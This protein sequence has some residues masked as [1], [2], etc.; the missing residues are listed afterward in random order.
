MFYEYK[1]KNFYNLNVGDRCTKTRNGYLA[2]FICF[3][4]CVKNDGISCKMFNDGSGFLENFY[5]SVIS[6]RSYKIIIKTCFALMFSF[7]GLYFL[8]GMAEF[9]Q[10]D[11]IKKAIKISFVYLMIGTDGWEFYNRFFVR[12]FKEGI[13]YLVFSIAAAFSDDEDINNAIIQNKLYDKTILF[14]SISNSLKLIISDKITA[15]IWGIFFSSLAGPIYLI[16][17]FYAI[18][19][20]LVSIL[21]ALLLYITSQFFISFLLAFGPIF[22]ALL[23]FEKTKNMFDKWISN[24][25]SFS[26]EQI[27]LITCISLFNSL[28]YNII[29]STFSYKV[30][31]EPLFSISIGIKKFNFFTFWRISENDI[32]GLFQ[33]LLIFLL[34]YLMKQFVQFM[35]DLGAKLGG[36]DLNSS[37]MTKEISDTIGSTTEVA[38]DWAKKNIKTLGVSVGRQLGYETK[39][40]RDRIDQTNKTLSAGRDK[41]FD[42]AEQKTAEQMSALTSGKLNEGESWQ[43]ALKNG[44]TEVKDIYERTLK[45][46]FDIAAGEDSKLSAA[47]KERGMDSSKLFDSSYFDLQQTSSFGGLLSNFVTSSIFNRG[48]TLDKAM[49][50]AMSESDSDENNNENNNEDENDNGENNNEN[51]GVLNPDLL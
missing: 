42:T 9:T 41:A 23:V 7:Y 43:D 8:L 33:V 32:P 6:D 17:I 24:L 12:F 50:R 38:K 34:A 46:N 45:R 4:K 19:L 48:R 20:F 2:E 29:K 14:N 15:R 39:E 5:K 47:L 13:D 35:A 31:V 16:L 51:D 22:F 21:T 3:K 27:F 25:I 26:L 44:N 49:S 40:G 11:L 10:E 30:C 36:G 28:A 18:M 1:D 37:G